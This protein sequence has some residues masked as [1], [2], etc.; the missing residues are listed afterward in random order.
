MVRRKKTT[1][2]LCVHIDQQRQQIEEIKYYA[3]K[4]QTTKVCNKNNFRKKKW[5]YSYA[6][7]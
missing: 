2:V 7:Q 3:F 4:C 5:N 6:L 1:L